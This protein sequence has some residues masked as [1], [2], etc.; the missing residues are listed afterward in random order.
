MFG[1]P[2]EIP[3]PGQALPGRGDAIQID[4]IHSVL[5]TSM[6]GPFPEDLFCLGKS[7]W[8]ITRNPVLNTFW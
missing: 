4:P 2:S 6:L 8:Q 3:D 5:G 7:I 1:R